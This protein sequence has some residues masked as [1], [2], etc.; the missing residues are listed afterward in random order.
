[1][2]GAT[3]FLDLID[4]FKEGAH[5]LHIVFTLVGTTLHDHIK[6]TYKDKKVDLKTVL[7]IADQLVRKKK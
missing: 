4:H 3:G 5:T 7:L 6:K 1:M 2:D